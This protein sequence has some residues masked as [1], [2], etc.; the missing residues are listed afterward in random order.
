VI[1]TSNTVPTEAGTPVDVTS[2]DATDLTSG[3]QYYVFVRSNCDDV[4]F[5]TW[6]GP[7]AFATA[8][9]NF[10]TALTNDE[11]CTAVELPISGECNFEYFINTGATTS[12]NENIP[13]PGC[14]FYQGGDVWFTVTVPANGHV[15]ID[16]MTGSLFDCGM[17]IYSEVENGGCDGALQLIDCDDDSSVNG[18]M[19]FIEAQDLA[20]Y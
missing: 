5:S 16:G 8:L 19:P 10:A 2:F 13:A 18:N 9:T 11:P 4:D 17:A 20:I 15:I 14:A 3:T 1:S 6:T 7:F 12:D